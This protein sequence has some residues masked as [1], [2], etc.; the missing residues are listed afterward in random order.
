MGYAGLERTVA[1]IRALGRDV[2][3]VAPTPTGGFD[4]GRCLERQDRGLWIG[5]V[6]ER[7][8]ITLENYQRHREQ[9]LVLLDLA[10][11]DMH[12]P[13]ARLDKILCDDSFCQTRINDVGLYR[14]A[15]HL[16]HEGSVA[17]FEHADMQSEIHRALRQSTEL[18]QK[19]NKRLTATR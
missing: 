11:K 4:V 17:L 13:I 6:D 9:V 1:L 19:A 12:L 5:G 16:S 18:A 8:R 3:F 10:E 15:G 14:D 2:I 7:C